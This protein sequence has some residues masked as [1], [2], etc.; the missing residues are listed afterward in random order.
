MCTP[1]LFSTVAMA[2]PGPPYEYAPSILPVPP[3]E[4]G[5]H[6]SR[7]I[8]IIVTF[9]VAGL[10][11]TRIIDWVSTWSPM[12]LESLSEPSSK[13]V[14]APG[15]WVAIDGVGDP[16]RPVD[17]GVGDGTATAW[18]VASRASATAGRKYAKPPAALDSTTAATARERMRKG[19]RRPRE[20][21]A[22]RPGRYPSS[23]G[24]NSIP[25][26][27]AAL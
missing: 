27:G 3:V 12:N 17:D 8:D 13:T 26:A 2:A 18:P 1:K 20:A 24:V 14:N 25:T 10:T 11:L 19:L 9:L 7:G 6:R 23:T 4:R 22:R 15:V 16:S 21:R 5:T